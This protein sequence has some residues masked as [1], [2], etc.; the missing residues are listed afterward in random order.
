MAQQVFI[1]TLLTDIICIDFITIGFDSGLIDGQATGILLEYAHGSRVRTHHTFS[2]WSLYPIYISNCQSD[3]QSD[4]A[5]SLMF[6]I[7]TT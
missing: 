7:A 5:T 2:F 3:G 4:H 1:P 6:S